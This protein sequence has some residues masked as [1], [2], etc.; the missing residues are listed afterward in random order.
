MPQPFILPC[1]YAYMVWQVQMSRV[2]FANGLWQGAR[3]LS[4]LPPDD[5][6]LVHCPFV[7][8]RLA[9]AGA[10]GWEL[11]SALHQP[12]ADAAQGTQLLYLKKRVG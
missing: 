12:S 11:V 4:A 3:P 6:P 1:A 5:D 10:D 2:T 7:W 8:D 9:A